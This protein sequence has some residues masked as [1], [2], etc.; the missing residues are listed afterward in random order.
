MQRLIRSARF[1]GRTLARR[2]RRVALNALTFRRG[3]VAHKYVSTLRNV[4]ACCG[5]LNGKSVLEIG[6]DP[7]GEF[8]R[9]LSTQRKL[10][11]AV[12]VNPCLENNVELTQY[13]LL[14]EDARKLPFADNSFDRILSISVFE[15]VQDLGVALAEMYRV[16]RP[17][18]YLFT[19][20][21]PIWSSVWGH[22]LWFYHGDEVRDW[23]NTPIPPYAHLLMSEEELRGWCHKKYRDDSLI[24]KICE[25]VYRSD[26]QNRLFYSDYEQIISA[27]PFRQLFMIGYADVPFPVGY[28]VEDAGLLFDRL[29]E[30][31]PGKSGFGY[32][33]ASVLLTK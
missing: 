12:G 6:C 23:R 2:I 17:G 26:E 20:F 21:G 5:S 1:R 7:E 32:H 19:E 4:E 31:C 33:V 3:G 9:Y 28:E 29:A 30:K 27:S 8:L 13:A 15:H 14:K 22:H 16:L 24:N 25:F 18:G 10:L 11:N